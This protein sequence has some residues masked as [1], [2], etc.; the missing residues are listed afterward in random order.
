M[1]AYD[2]AEIKAALSLQDVADLLTEYG[3][4]PEFTSFGLVCATICHNLPGE[5]SRKLYYYTNTQL[6]HC[7]TGCADPSFD[8]FELTIKVFDIQRRKEIDLNEAVRYIAHKFGILTT[9]KTD[10]TTS[11]EDWNVLN[12]YDR[13]QEIEIR[14]Y[15]IK[16]KEYDDAILDRLNYDVKIGPWLREGI[17]Q[18]AIE[19]AR[20]GYFPGGEQI[21]IPHYDVDGRF[22]GLRGRTL[23][24]EDAERYGKYRPVVINK[25]LYNH[26]LGTNLYGLNWTK[27]NI[28]KTKQAIVF[29]SEKS[30]LL[31]ETLL[32]EEANVSVACCGSNLSAY[33]MQLLREAG[34]N[35]VVIAF[36]KQYEKLNTEESKRWSKKLTAIHNRYK[37]EFTISF[38]WDKEN[39][40]GYKSSPIDEGLDKF[41]YLY[42]KRIVL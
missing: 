41:L 40:L 17:S 18:R 6:F 13:I 32:G 37:N 26:P 33:Q 10:E 38:I 20:I 2:K 4:E 24:K 30:V 42:K 14:D 7:Y 34:A 1:I 29:E 12:R 16:L 8:L 5:G 31:A 9:Y 15:S 22:I 3:G 23:C 35:E 25:L 21:T 28:R 11:L 27:D 36:D 39:V 19:K